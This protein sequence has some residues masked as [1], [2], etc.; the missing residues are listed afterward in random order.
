MQKDV[1]P[2]TICVKSGKNKAEKKAKSQ[3]LGS[4]KAAF[5]H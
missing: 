4:D 1:Q 5:E 3:S 2:A